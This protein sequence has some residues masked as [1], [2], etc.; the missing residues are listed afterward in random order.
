MALLD[1]YPPVLREVLNMP[2]NDKV[3]TGIT[4]VNDLMSGLTRSYST[5]ES[6]DIL[7]TLVI[8]AVSSDHGVDD[9]ERVF[10]NDIFGRYRKYY[11][12]QDFHAALSRV[13]RSFNYDLMFHALGRLSHL[14]SS[15]NCMF[16]LFCACNGTVTA[17]EL[18]SFE[19]FV[20]K[21]SHA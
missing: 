1:N 3:R 7:L 19:E 20:E 21:L 14:H 6:L 12:L 16:W 8:Y 4:T 2:Y 5:A 17:D 9:R 11:S 10:Y 18:N 15:A 13:N